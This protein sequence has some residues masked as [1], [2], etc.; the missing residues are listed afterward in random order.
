MLL[1]VSDQNDVAIQG[2][3]LNDLEICSPVYESEL[4]S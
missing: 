4:V 2:L 3:V 1:R